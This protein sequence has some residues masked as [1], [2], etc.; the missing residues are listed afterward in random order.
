MRPRFTQSE[1]AS[2]N[3]DPQ[4]LVVG[5]LLSQSRNGISEKDECKIMHRQVISIYSYVNI[6]DTIIDDKILM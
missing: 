1:N 6:V 4:P 5:I 2:T 3:F